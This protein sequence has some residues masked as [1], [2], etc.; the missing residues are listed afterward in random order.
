[1]GLIKDGL[2]VVSWQNGQCLTSD[3]MVVDSLATSYLSST[4]SF[5]GSAAEAAAIRNRSKYAAIMLTH[6]FVPVAVGTL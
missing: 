4:S 2:K 5:P 3:A 1:M 6:I